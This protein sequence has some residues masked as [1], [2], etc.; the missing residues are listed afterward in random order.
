MG[1]EVLILMENQ[2]RL[3]TR[4]EIVILGHDSRFGG[5]MTDLCFGG[6]G[7]VGCVG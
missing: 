4:S 1:S 5:Q 2:S 7:L 6:R 3:W